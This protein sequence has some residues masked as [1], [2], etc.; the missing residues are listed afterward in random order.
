[1]SRPHDDGWIARPRWRIRRRNEIA[2]GP[3]KADLLAAVE[4][5]GSI[6]GAARALGMSYRRAWLLVETMNRCFRRPLVSTSRWRRGG[7]SL[8]AEGREVL[9]L[10]RRAEAESLAAAAAA[11]SALERHLVG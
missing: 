4:S 3:G 5:A 7:A 10:Y 6:S 8:T 1:V 2:L 9:A 11:L